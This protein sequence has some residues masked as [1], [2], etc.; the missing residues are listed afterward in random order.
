V[1]INT[2]GIKRVQQCA[3]LNQW[4]KSQFILDDFEEKTLDKALDR[5]ANLAASW[6]EEE[7]KMH[8]I[9]AIITVADPN[10]TDV[11]KTYFERPLTGIIQ[12]YN[13]HVITD[14][15]IAQP[16]LAGDPDKPYFFLQEFKQAQRFGRTDPQGQML[17]AMLLAQQINADDKIIYGCYVVENNWRFTTLN[18]LNYCVS[19]QFN[20]TEK[21]E[22][23]SIVFILRQL[24]T[25]ILNR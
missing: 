25:L 1:V 14:C 5:Y 20:A 8:F 2:F 22:L 10:I 24:K 4:M 16:K 17:A 15:M 6:N 11:C 21:I 23:L 12:N 19:R 3:E 13:M 18:G 7:L 9:S